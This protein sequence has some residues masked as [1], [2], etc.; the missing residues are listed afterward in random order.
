MNAQ[1]EHASPTDREMEEFVSRVRPC[2]HDG[3]DVPADL[4]DHIDEQILQRLRGLDYD[5]RQK[6]MLL[7]S[8]LRVDQ[9]NHRPESQNFKRPLTTLIPLLQK[10][11]VECAAEDPDSE[12]EGKTP[13]DADGR[14]LT[15]GKAYGECARVVAWLLEA[16]WRTRLTVVLSHALLSHE[17]KLKRE[18]F[19]NGDIGN[20]LLHDWEDEF[21]ERQSSPTGES[22]NTWIEGFTAGILNL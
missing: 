3:N 7:L 12:P 6:L 21:F 15:S 19:Y 20:D 11:E 2:L 17:T 8:S 4:K 10:A 5:G 22:C 18:T 1:T 16:D 9:H 14:R 13:D